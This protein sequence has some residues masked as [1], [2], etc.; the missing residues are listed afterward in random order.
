MMVA[1][2]SDL[3]ART[4][5]LFVS[6]RVWQLRVSM[7]MPCDV[8]LFLRLFVVGSA[9]RKA[10]GWTLSCCCS[11]VLTRKAWERGLTS[12]LKL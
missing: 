2:S 8:C 9:V 6:G 10:L 11:F 5:L 1:N 7:R 3:C 12:A 4:M